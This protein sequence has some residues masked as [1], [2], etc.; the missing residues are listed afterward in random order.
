MYEETFP[1]LA[2]LSNMENWTFTPNGNA[3]VDGKKLLIN[4]F[5]TI[6]NIL[7]SL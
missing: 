2:D 7:A 5:D 1:T 3:Q 6:E 4:L